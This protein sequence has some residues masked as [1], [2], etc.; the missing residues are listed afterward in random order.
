[1]GKY[2]QKNL[3]GS[4]CCVLLLSACHD[5]NRNMT[6]VTKGR[7]R[8]ATRK[9]RASTSHELAKRKI[10]SIPRLPAL[11]AISFL[12]FWCLS[13]SAHG[14]MIRISIP[15]APAA[16]PWKSHLGCLRGRS[17]LYIAGNRFVWCDAL[18]CVSIL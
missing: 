13:V 11:S 9:K 5:T 1:M 18:V 4:Q 2:P 12:L 15:T 17:P 14:A 16:I 7:A 8:L 6:R 3:K 10:H